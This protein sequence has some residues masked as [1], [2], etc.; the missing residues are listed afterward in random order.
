GSNSPPV[1]DQWTA[2]PLSSP[3][4]T[5]ADISCISS[6]SLPPY[7]VTFHVPRASLIIQ[8]SGFRGIHLCPLPILFA[9]VPHGSPCRWWA[10]WGMALRLS[11]KLGLAGSRKE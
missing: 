9:P 3:L 1:G 7:E 6:G 11:F 10:H 4:H 5:A 8:R 2:Q